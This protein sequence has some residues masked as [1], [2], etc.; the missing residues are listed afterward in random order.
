MFDRDP[1]D[2]FQPGKKEHARLRME[3]SADLRALFHWNCKQVYVWLQVD[4]ENDYYVRCV[5]FVYLLYALWIVFCVLYGRP[6]CAFASA[7]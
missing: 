2:Y 1:M 7:Q 6:S 5:V 4:Y 3:L